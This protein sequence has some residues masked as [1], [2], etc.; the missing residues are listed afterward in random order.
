MSVREETVAAKRRNLK[1]R[2]TGKFAP[3]D[4]HVADAEVVESAGSYKWLYT[5]DLSLLDGRVTRLTVEP[6]SPAAERQGVT[7]VQVL[8]NVPLDPIVRAV[9]RSAARELERWD[10]S[11]SRRIYENRDG[12]L[13][14]LAVAFGLEASE[15]MRQAMRQV[16]KPVLRRPS[17]PR[18]R[19]PL[20]DR[21]LANEMAEYLAV[22]ASGRMTVAKWLASRSLPADTFEKHR[23][24]AVRRGLFVGLG[25]GRAGGQLTAK[26][27]A[28]LRET[29]E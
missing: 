9:R 4:W 27:Q 20:S 14:P 23:R 5:L 29:K 11:G 28:A 17:A 18:G 1:V 25:Y 2:S 22:V 16:A 13:V 6:F 10:S 7:K 3:A 12:E 8:R 24:A 26:G 15:G 19:R 21:D